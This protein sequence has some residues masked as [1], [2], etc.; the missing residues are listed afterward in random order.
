MQRVD[1]A[2]SGRGVCVNN[3]ICIVFTCGGNFVVWLVFM[4]EMDAYMQRIRKWEGLFMMITLSPRVSFHFRDMMECL[5]KFEMCPFPH[6]RWWTLFDIQGDET[7]LDLKVK[8]WVCASL[9]L[10]LCVLRGR[11]SERFRK[12]S[13]ACLQRSYCLFKNWWSSFIYCSLTD[14]VSYVML[15]PSTCMIGEI[16]L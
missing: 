1:Y 5:W 14:T 13:L 9:C 2:L 4:R 8:D 3:W 11:E 10:S 15:S 6:T 7:L 12:P 16:C